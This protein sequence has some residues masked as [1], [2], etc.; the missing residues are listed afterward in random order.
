MF[1]GDSTMLKRFPLPAIFAC[2][3]LA[4][5][6]ATTSAQVLLDEGF[7]NGQAN[8]WEATGGS[9]LLGAGGNPGWYMGVPYGDWYW[10]TLS[11]ESAGNPLIGNLSRHGGALEVSVDALVLQLHNWFNEPMD[12]GNFPVVF[13]FT[14]AADPTISVYWIGPGM[15]AVANGW[16]TITCEIPDPTSTT[17]PP[18]WGGTGDEDPNTYEPIL[19]PG[20]TYASVMANIG[21]FR[22]TTAQPGYF[23]IPSWWEAGF[24][25][26]K[27]S[28]AGGATCYANC[29]GSTT[30]PVLNV[31]DFSCFLSRFAAGD[32]YANCDS[33]T[34]EPVLNVADFSCFLAKFAA[35]CR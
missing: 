32:A 29:D 14:H 9:T 13:Q 24:D 5:A 28:L 35:G 27:V 4:M 11:T 26:I 7:E 6:A 12:P 16:T 10:L 34:P 1:R 33:S 22:V 31:A 25:N 8:G 23:Y 2:C 3:G 21:N 19:P 20:Y 15:P 18:G 17:L 30:E